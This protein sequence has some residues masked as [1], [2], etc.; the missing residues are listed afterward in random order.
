MSD[1]KETLEEYLFNNRIN[2][3]YFVLT[4]KNDHPM[5]DTEK[6]RFYIRPDGIDGDTL[7]FLIDD[8]KVIPDIP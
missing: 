3:C 2:T 1:T 6:I 4:V 8:G 7:H 5:T